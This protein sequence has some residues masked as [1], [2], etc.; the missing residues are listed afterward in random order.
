MVLDANYYE[1]I[2]DEI[3]TM[4]FTD[5]NVLATR[6][7]LALYSC[8]RTSVIS[9]D[10]FMLEVKSSLIT[11]NSSGTKNCKLGTYYIQIAT[12][13]EQDVAFTREF[14]VYT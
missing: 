11:R 10:Q 5:L 3:V 12:P 9:R 13:I 14:S 1:I 2:Y 8:K 4:A 7:C 6:R